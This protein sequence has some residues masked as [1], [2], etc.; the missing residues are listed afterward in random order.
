MVLNYALPAA[1]FLSIVKAN[2]EMLAVDLKLT[3]I[4]CVVLIGCFMLVYLV[5]RYMY[6]DTMQ[7]SAISALISGSPTIGFRFRGASA[8]LRRLRFRGT[9]NSNSRDR[10]QR[11]RN[12]A[13]VSLF[14][15]GRRVPGESCGRNRPDRKEAQSLGSGRKGSDGAG[16]M[17]SD[18]CQ[19]LVLCGL[20][21]PSY[22]DPSFQLIIGANSSIA[23]FAAG[24]TLSSVRININGQAVMG[25]VLKLIVMPLLILIAGI[26]FRMDPL[27]LKM[28]VVCA[29]LP[30]AFSGIIIASQK[31]CYVA[32]G[33]SSL[34][35][36]DHSLHGLLS[37]LDMD[38]RREPAPVPSGLDL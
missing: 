2:R 28:L 21:W 16:G 32:T 18:P 23:V 31:N 11:N 9:G 19:I 12:S 35:L 26:I 37:A 34:A 7:E 25:S 6:R 4:S 29:A 15:T 30:P 3:L 20:K 22:L 38:H 10:S 5:Y 27:N 14:N 17:G 1:L 13:S 8:D 33:T 36:S 24:I